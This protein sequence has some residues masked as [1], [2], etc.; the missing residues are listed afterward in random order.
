MAMKFTDEQRRAIETLDKSILVSAAAGSGKTAVLIERILRI[1]LEGKANVDEMLVVTFTKAAAA[2]MKLRLASAIRRRMQEHPEDSR[3]M[4]DQLGRLYRAYISTIDSFALRVIREFFYETDIEPDFGTCDE[5]QG[6]LL[7]REAVNAL[8][9]EGFEDDAFI[10]RDGDEA[11]RDIGF[12]AFLRLYSEER[13]EEGFKEDLMSA[14]SKLR[15]MPDY[16]AWARARAEELRVTEESF[17]GSALHDAM[18]EDARATMGRAYE[19]VCRVRTLLYEADLAEMYEAKLLPEVTAITDICEKLEAG[20]LDDDVMNLIRTISYPQLR[21]RKIEEERYA[22]IRDTIKKIRQAYKDEI[23]AWTARYLTPD[24][25][26]R[27]EEMNDT[28]RYTLY[29]IRLLEE[30]EKKY[31]EKKKERRIMDFA[32]MEHNA[33]RILGSGQAAEILRNRF[34]YVFVDEY[35]DT[36]NIQEYLI[37]RVSRPDNVFKVG[38]I[39]QSIYKFRQAEPELFSKVYREYSDPACKDGITIDL[40]MNFR[41]NDA[42]VRYI[43]RVFE[44]VM[45]GYDE[46]ARLYTGCSCNEEYDFI[47]EVHI[48]TD[49]GQTDDTETEE[50]IDE[51]TINL[52][53]EEAEAAYIA[54][55]AQGLIGTEFHDTKTKEIRKATARDIVILFRAV[56]VRGDIMARALRARSIEPHV[57]EADDYF[58]TVEISVAL[59]LLSCIDNMK[60]DVSLIATLHSGVFGWSPEELAMVRILHSE[61][62]KQAAHNG[63]KA[64]PYIRPAFW[65]ALEWLRIAGPEGELREKAGAAAA[66]ITEWR[67][68]SRMMPLDDFVWKVLVDSGLYRLAGAMNGGARRQANLRVLADRAGKYSRES[69]SSLSSFISFLDVMRKKKISSGQAQT[70]GSDDDVIRIST[71]HKSKG[72]EYPFVIVGGLG[73]GFQMDSSEKKF[74]FDSSIGVGMPYIDPSRRYWR[75]TLMQRVITEKS[76]RDSYS[77]ELRILY[78]AMTRARNRLILVGT[79]KSEAKLME[80]TPRPKTFLEVMRDVL[81]T[82]CNTYHISPLERTDT[83]RKLSRALSV[84]ESARAAKPAESDPVYRE[85]DRRFTFRYPDEDLLTAKAKYSVSEIRRNELEAEKPDTAEIEGSDT[86]EVPDSIRERWRVSAPADRKVTAAEIGT[87]YHRIM[88]FVDFAKAVRAD[89]TVDSEYIAERAGFLAEHGSIPDEVYRK[90]DTG[91]IE[92][93][94]AS[95]IG[96]RAAEAARRGTLRREKPFTLKT[97][98]G[99][100]AILVQ[101]VIDCCFEEAGKMI[102]IDYKSGYVRPD[103]GHEEEL[104]RIR[105]EYRVQV[106]LYEE[107]IEKGTG[108]EVGE[109]YLYLLA[110]GEALRLK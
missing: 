81:R 61:Y 55:I 105:N 62:M 30:F 48:L 5:V 71:I 57:E 42:T 35:Q 77:E 45:D 14:Y 82:P 68:L 53:K 44:E 17:A 84:V 88:E 28:Y 25:A 9:E 103:L 104:E 43:N 16:F 54:D 51:E 96:R 90:I 40:S 95:D 86:N 80:Y 23:K 20:R 108:R 18:L 56:R 92:G 1:I 4:K 59:S 12:R 7:R 33:V 74:S 109:S 60:R 70:V 10:S 87:A 79:C 47:P 101:G 78:V 107:A 3:R 85:I 72:L 89:G 98:R 67:R 22:P 38:D 2:E 97:E 29:Y 83:A 63:E 8:F 75:P 73:H 76:H 24:F 21:A 64:G 106:E 102:L 11:I 50:V 19:A 34:R 49:E 41:S 13:T 26:S 100:R 52:S 31:A 91:R 46:R 65:E 93:F 94:F 32:D 6:E 69:I 37:G 110:T 36:N 15:T 39:K 99:G 66:K 58:D 27:L